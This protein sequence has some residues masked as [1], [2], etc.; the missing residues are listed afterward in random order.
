MS[1]LSTI[2]LFALPLAAAPVIIHLL[3]RRRHQVIEWGA[4]QFLLD[5]A[6]FRRRFNRLD[7]LLLMLL[8]ALLLALFIMALAQ[9]RV[10]FADLGGGANRDVI[11]VLD[12]SMSTARRL[13]SATAMNAQIEQAV[14]IINDL[15]A[16][17]TVRVLLASTTPRWLVSAATQASA[18][19]KAQLNAQLHEIKPTL[20]SVDWLAALGE[21]LDAAVPDDAAG[22]LIV[23]VTDG[24]AAGWRADA[25]GAW[26]QFAAYIAEQST[27]AAV[28]I[29]DIGEPGDIDNLA[30]ESVTPSR[31]TGTLDEPIV[32]TARLVNHG[33]APQPASLASWSVNGEPIGVTTTPDIEPGSAAHVRIK[34]I[35]TD[36]GVHEVRCEVQA[37]D[38]L[39]HDNANAHVMQIIDRVPILIAQPTF[40][41]DPMHTNTA[42]LL[43]VLGYDQ[44]GRALD[45]PSVFRPRLI[46]TSQLADQTFDDYHAVVLTDIG[47][48]STVAIGRLHDYIRAGGGVWIALGD[49]TD[50]RAFNADLFA[51]GGGIAPLALAGPPRGDARDREHFDPVHPPQIHHPATAL[52]A[53][54]EQLDL[55]LGQIYRRFTFNTADGADQ[56]E[57]LVTAGRGEPLVLQRQLGAGRVIVQAVPL[58]MQWS[59]L[60][61]LHAYVVMVHEWLWHLCEP[62]ATRW[63]VRPGESLVATLPA[64]DSD[65]R[66][67]QVLPP[68][69]EPMA[70][71]VV[72]DRERAR[73][74]FRHTAMPGRY[75]LLRPSASPT[76]FIVQ[77][78]PDESRLASL[79]AEARHALT[80]NGRVSFNGEPLAMPSVVHDSDEAEPFWWRMLGLVLAVMLIEL[81]LGAWQNR[82]RTR[83]MRAGATMS[84]GT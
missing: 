65:L 21:A 40:T 34:H 82:R 31:S 59:N 20:G 7:D 25:A 16:G 50:A 79:D 70:V 52:L 71:A 83:P 53:D 62:S 37:A 12:V 44:S 67:W 2:F 47:P 84:Q 14:K 61:L 69:G 41:R 74:T 72:Q 76:P 64:A 4:M 28:N 81:L 45:A 6:A 80:V 24:Q 77:R 18:Q 19:V 78:D 32:F 29:I 35:L 68:D 27:P 38:A 51:D 11:V 36:A 46:T 33:R 30:I 57:V 17:D 63:N 43:A 13:N 22:R 56:T 15:N 42:Y 1:F 55:D 48:L 10:R 3:H 58:G 5:S 66:A 75:Q 39:R 49:E 60:P 23:V 8:R 26:Q 73:F 54:T 9:P